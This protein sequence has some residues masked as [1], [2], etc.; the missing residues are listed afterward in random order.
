M[1]KV[2]IP[3][4]LILHSIF[5]HHNQNGYE[6]CELNDFAIKFLSS[7]EYFDLRVDF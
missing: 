6:V 5:S 3:M 4:P 1:D 7:H 2:F